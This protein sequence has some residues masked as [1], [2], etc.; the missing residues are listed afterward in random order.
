LPSGSIGADHGLDASLG[1]IVK[2]FVAVITLISEEPIGI[3][4]V[5]PHQRLIAFDPR[6]PHRF[7]FEGERVAFGI[8]AEMDFGREAAARAAERLLL[9]IPPLRRLHADAS[10]GGPRLARISKAASPR[11]CSAA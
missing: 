1:Q 9:L 4:I 6:A 7:H 5:K 10:A 2:D 3:G 11:A 8:R